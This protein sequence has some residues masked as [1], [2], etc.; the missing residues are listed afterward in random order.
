MKAN[1]LGDIDGDG[2]IDAADI[3]TLTYEQTV[4]IYRAAFWKRYGYDRLALPVAAKMFDL[5][6]NMGPKQAHRIAQRALRACGQMV[7]EDGILG[8][9][10]LTAIATVAPEMLR[11]SMCS[12]AAGFYR[13]LC[14][15]RPEL[16]KYL[17]GWLRRA[18]T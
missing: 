7:V 10:S 3:R 4:A 13:I 17:Q 15:R 16:Q 11:V 8:P 9:R 12:E 5:C 18:Y 6:V 2:D 1:E 14:I